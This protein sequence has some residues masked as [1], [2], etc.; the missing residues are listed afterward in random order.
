MK[1]GVESVAAIASISR[2]GIRRVGVIKIDSQVRIRNLVFALGRQEQTT[3]INASC[4]QVH[5]CNFLKPRLETHSV[6]TVGCS[7]G[8]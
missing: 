1:N 6:K 5:G 8:T 3:G 2:L 4:V 7:H